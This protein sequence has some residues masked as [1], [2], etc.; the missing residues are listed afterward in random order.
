MS[1]FPE[2]VPTKNCMMKEIIATHIVE[3][4]RAA[5]VAYTNLC[6]DILI[7]VKGQSL[8]IFEKELQDCLE[9]RVN[10][11]T[12]IKDDPVAQKLAE[13]DDGF[14]SLICHG[15][16]DVSKKDELELMQSFVRE[17]GT[18]YPMI[19]MGD[20]TEVVISYGRRIKLDIADPGFFDQLDAIVDHLLNHDDLVAFS[21]LS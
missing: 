9:R 10:A 6:N 18:K 15:Y 8:R 4:L 1:L 14:R 12:F 11:S 3:N 16:G 13:K 5:D 7:I 19:C 2:P 21:G 17:L 20:S